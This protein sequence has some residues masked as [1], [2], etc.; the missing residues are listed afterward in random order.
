MP[1]RRRP[2]NDRAKEKGAPLS[3]V[4]DQSERVESKVEEASADLGDVNE[5]L[6]SEKTKGTPLGAVIGALEKS[7]DAEVKVREASQELVEVNDA[8]SNEIDARL[9]IEDELSESKAA[10]R[11]SRVQEKR[12]RHEAM[13]DDITGLPNAT[14]FKDRVKN[15]LAQ[16]QRHSWQVAVMFIDL[17]RFKKINDTHGHDMGDAVLRMVAD[18]LKEFVRGGDTV[19]R[20]SGDEFL[21]LMLEAKDEDNARTMAQRII[22]VLAAPAVVNGIEISVQASIGLAMYPGDGTT[23][24]ALLKHADLS[25]YE[26]KRQPSGAVLPRTA[27]DADA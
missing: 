5:V 26:A 20:R 1:H 27:E 24:S 7:S 16:A 23:A 11:A 12:A 15:A 10:L 25:M 21:F 8:L 17:D 18:R 19:S 13:H 14:L 3:R 6:R 9:E 22:S 2:E 4:L